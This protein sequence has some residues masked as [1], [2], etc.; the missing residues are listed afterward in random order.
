MARNTAREATRLLADDG[1]VT[2]VHGMGVFVRKSQRLLQFGSERYSNRLREET[3]L[4]PYR[5][6]VAKQGRTARVDCTS[7]TRVPPPEQIASRLN[8]DPET[9]TVARRENWYYADD[10]PVQ[11]GVTSIQW[12][13]ADGSVLATSAQMG[14]GSLY[15]RFEDR[16]H[17]IT[18]IREEVSARMPSPEET[19]ELRIPDGVPVLEVV[20]TGI[21]QNNEP[22]E[23]THFVRRADFNGLDYIKPV[24][25]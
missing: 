7:I 12:H 14:K 9:D 24:E 5:A 11:V 23:V 10:D 18:P 1:P 2:A 3:R 25:D 20:H 15:A 19:E 17:R 13:I 4:S 22:F 8:L 21:D 16:G 6:E